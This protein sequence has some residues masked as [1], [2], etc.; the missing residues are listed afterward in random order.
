M[1]NWHQLRVIAR[2]WSDLHGEQ[3]WDVSKMRANREAYAECSEECSRICRELDEQLLRRYEDS[4]NGLQTWLPPLQSRLPL[5]LLRSPGE[6]APADQRVRVLQIQDAMLRMSDFMER[7]ANGMD[8]GDGDGV[9][10]QWF[11]S[12]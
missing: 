4:W 2:E 8:M 5:R 9:G 3:P 12:L 11:R 10:N 6:D 7:L 1:V